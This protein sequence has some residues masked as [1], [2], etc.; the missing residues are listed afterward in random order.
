MSSSCREFFTV[1]LHGLR[2]ELRARATSQGMTESAVLRRALAAALGTGQT[3]PSPPSAGAGG[4][5]IAERVKLSVRIAKPAAN[6]LDHNARTAGFSRGAYLVRLIEGAPPAVASSDRAAMFN[7]LNASSAELA[8]LS[9]DINHL[10][11]LLP[12]GR[13]EA[14]R[15]YAPRHEALDADVRRHLALAAPVLAELSSL[16]LTVKHGL[17]GPRSRNPL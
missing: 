9:Q 11:Q 8:V 3:E 17:V 15:A 1:D 13:V 10:T 7:A 16:C 5:T 14:A 12:Q 2:A 6:R 4:S